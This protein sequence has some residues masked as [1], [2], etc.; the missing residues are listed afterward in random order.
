MQTKR[1]T[2][3]EFIALYLRTLDDPI[4]RPLVNGQR[5]FRIDLLL[6]NYDFEP[7]LSGLSLRN[8][9]FRY[10][11]FSHISIDETDFGGALCHWADFSKAHFNT[12]CFDQNTRFYEAQFTTEQLLHLTL[13]GAALELI[14]RV[15]SQRDPA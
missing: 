5:H 2:Q 6:M 10:A 9:S 4:Y 11:D 1:I 13:P 3:R 12:I 8:L 15:S 14:N 7:N